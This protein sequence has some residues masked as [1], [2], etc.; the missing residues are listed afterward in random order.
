MAG[1]VLCRAADVPADQGF[2]VDVPGYPPL[3]VFRLDG[4]FYVVDDTCTHGDASLSEGEI[5]GG[6]VVCPFHL[7]AFDIRTGRAT[8][9][10]CLRPLQVYAALLVDGDV[11]LA[12]PVA[13]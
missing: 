4:A 13:D 5:E 8:A 6:A 10:P 3:A 11:V 1:V 12:Q 2:R 7:G 9:A